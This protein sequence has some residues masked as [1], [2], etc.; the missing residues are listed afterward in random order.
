MQTTNIEVL[1]FDLGGVLIELTGVGT[2]MKW[3]ALPEEELWSRWLD[4]RAVREFESGKSTADDFAQA[5]VSEFNLQ[6]DEQAFM[7]EFIAWPSGPYHGSTE[8]LNRLSGRFRLGCLSNTNHLHWQRFWDETDLLDCFHVHLPSH[9]TGLM[10]PDSQVYEHAIS[11]LDTV[12]ER[13]LFLDDNQIN[14]DAAR[15]A[16]IDAEVTRTLDGV[17]EVL[18]SRH[19][20][21]EQD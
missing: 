6:I 3:S 19:L 9:H 2:M 21:D 15:R 18:A 5:I 20:I 16:G 7:Q 11:T 8:F 14:V 12:P 10:K 4:S 13:I 17:R 1:L